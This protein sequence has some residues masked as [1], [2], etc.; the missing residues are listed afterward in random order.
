[1]T[2]CPICVKDIPEDAVYC[3]Y[4]GF[5]VKTGV[6]PVRKKHDEHGGRYT[7]GMIFIVLGVIFLIDEYTSYSF[8][9]LWPLILIA[10][11]VAMILK[12]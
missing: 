9:E 8:G 11:G 6:A 7:G 3:P 1:M 12:R 4:C 2:K 10:L 5:D